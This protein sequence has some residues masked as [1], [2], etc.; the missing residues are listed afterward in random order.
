MIENVHV[1]SIGLVSAVYFRIEFNLSSIQFQLK[2]W[3]RQ[4][5]GWYVDTHY[6]MILHALWSSTYIHTCFSAEVVPCLFYGYSMSWKLPE[7]WH[8]LIYHCKNA[9]VASTTFLGSLSCISV[10]IIQQIHKC[11]KQMDKWRPAANFFKSPH[12]L[13]QLIKKVCNILGLFQIFPT[14]L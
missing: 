9:W 7:A 11:M 3:R 5:D 8:V 2:N 13:L 1:E 4:H 10:T 6:K 14:I 12:I